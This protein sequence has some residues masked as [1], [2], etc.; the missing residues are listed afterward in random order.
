MTGYRGKPP[1]KHSLHAAA[2]KALER[3]PLTIEQLSDC[4]DVTPK[5]I[6]NN[7]KSWRD[8]GS[9]VREGDYPRFVYRAVQLPIAEE[10]EPPAP[11]LPGGKSA[12]FPL[13]LKLFE[14]L[15]ARVAA[16]AAEADAAAGAAAEPYYVAVQFDVAKGT[17]KTRAWR[18]GNDDADDD[19]PGGST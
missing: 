13:L 1:R 17:A 12:T 4:L 16:Y 14:D 9:I 3:G 18:L 10:P 5:Q 6:S 8:K 7:M 15:E 11:E 19:E 2:L